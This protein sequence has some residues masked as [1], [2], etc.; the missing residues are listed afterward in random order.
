[1]VVS[2]R[3]WSH[4]PLFLRS[5]LLN[6]YTSK[7]FQSEQQWLSKKSIIQSPMQQPLQLI[8]S[9]SFK[10]QSFHLT[11]CQENENLHFPNNL[12]QKYS[13]HSANVRFLY[14]LHLSCQRWQFTDPNCACKQ[15]L[16][17]LLCPVFRET[18]R[19]ACF[20]SWVKCLHQSFKLEYDFG[21][22]HS[23]IQKM[24]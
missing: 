8:R 10:Y 5:G 6:R 22:S 13:T 2:E 24:T 17:S 1:M 15:M 14:W 7:R 9:H 18:K 12:R 23:H 3:I 4:P 20:N 11:G 19:Y 21:P 16:S